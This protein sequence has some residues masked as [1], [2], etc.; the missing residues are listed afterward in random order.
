MIRRDCAR[1]AKDRPRLRQGL[2]ATVRLMKLAASL[3]G[4]GLL[5][6][7][8]AGAGC[9]SHDRPARP[10]EQPATVERLRPEVLDERPHDTAAF[11]EGLELSGGVL[12]E[13]T[14]LP[15]HS[16]LREL[17]PADGTVRRNQSLS[18]GRF[19]EGVT[20][21]GPYIWQ[22][23]WRDRVAVQW[24][25]ARLTPV[26]EVR[27]DGEGWGLCYD[28]SRLIRSD[29]TSRLRFHE[30]ASFAETGSVPV[31][32]SG[33]PVTG[34]NELE[35]VGGAV[36]ANVFPTDELVRIDPAGGRVTAVV[37]AS[38]LLPPARRTSQ[39]DVL[40]GIA[41]LGDGTFLLTGKFWPA[42]F[43][44]RFVPAGDQPRGPV[45][46]AADPARRPRGA[47]RDASESW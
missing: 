14:G 1:T 20:V 10:Y 22:L 27:F 19:G 24:D 23:T 5:A 43:R 16:Q 30:P 36:W 40:N 13:G 25:R 47:V 31:T 6:L 15:G 35:C 8:V 38:G 44:V 46:A 7:T 17:N 33:R 34:L 28:G 29:G 11:T 12:V 41:S 21:A 37:D 3:L 2:P 18:G 32:R 39:T 4:A 45:N 9:G 26:R 42:M